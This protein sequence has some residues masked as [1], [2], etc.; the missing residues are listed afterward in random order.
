[1]HALRAGHSY[2]LLMAFS[3]EDDFLHHSIMRASVTITL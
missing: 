3:Q 1:M 2:A